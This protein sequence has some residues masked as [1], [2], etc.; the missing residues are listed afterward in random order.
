MGITTRVVASMLVACAVLPAGAAGAD[1]A[2]AGYWELQGG[3]PKTV[4]LAFGPTWDD[5]NG[6][7]G[8]ITGRSANHVAFGFRHPSVQPAFDAVR[9][10]WDTPPS[11]LV[12]GK[13]IPIRVGR[14]RE[15]GPCFAGGPV[16]TLGSDFRLATVPDENKTCEGRNT[17]GKAPGRR[18]DGVLEVQ[19]HLHLSGLKGG[20]REVYAYRWRKGTAPA[21]PDDPYAGV[22]P[23]E[24]R[25]AKPDA[26]LGGGGAKPDAADGRSEDG[27]G[28][29]PPDGDGSARPGSGDA[30]LGP[31]LGTWALDGNGYPGTLRFSVESDV[32]VGKLRYDVAKAWETLTDV[33]Y[34]PAT[35]ELSF[36]RPWTGK[37]KFQQYRGLV[38]GRSIRG[39][40]TDVNS[41]GASFPWTATR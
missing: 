27:T 34:A 15:V 31:V 41:P 25:G 9:F 24:P 16:A 29:R 17:D 35:G 7:V 26:T 10:W 11:V 13:L 28:D 40:F 38:A 8:R 19:V 21:V 32:L 23:G 3:M 4:G 5:Q 12:P 18:D 1:D 37:P 30:A 2:E 22:K 36:T 14:V 39:R 33:K 20:Y 6:W